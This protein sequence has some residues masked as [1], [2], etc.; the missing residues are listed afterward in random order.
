MI[1]LI[2]LGA[3]ALLIGLSFLS[4]IES[5]SEL[6]QSLRHVLQDMKAQRTKTAVAMP[7]LAD[8]LQG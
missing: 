8:R 5:A 2:T 1:T 7:T 3:M 6:T 4:F